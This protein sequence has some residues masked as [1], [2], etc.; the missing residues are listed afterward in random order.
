MAQQHSAFSKKHIEE[1]TAAKRTLLE[2][3]NLPPA[4]IKFIRENSTAIQAVLISIFLGICG[5]SYYDY[6]TTKKMN[7]A[8]ALYSRA[9]QEP[10]AAGRRQ[11]M[12]KVV[13]DYAS[14]GAALWSRIALAHEKSSEDRLADL[15][16]IAND[17]K[18]DNPVYPLLQ[19]DLARSYEMK[20]ELDRALAVYKTLAEI[21]GFAAVSYLAM[22]RIY[23]LKDDGAQAVAMYEKARV[24]PELPAAA[25]ARLED[26]Q[27]RL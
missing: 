5:W 12:E 17:V 23:E 6:Y 22:G 24:Q 26:R 20:N 16:R 27:A 25:K 2:E 18:R 10:T 9:Q 11:F 3:L 19:Y 15:E 1:V 7:D 13:A 21:P 14:T 4:V 8:A